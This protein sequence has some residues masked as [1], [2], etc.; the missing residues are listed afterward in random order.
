MCG[1]YI[2]TSPVDVLKA[3]FDFSETGPVSL[4]R[5]NAAPRQD[6]P[7]ITKA[8][9]SRVLKP[10]QWGLVPSWTKDLN[11]ANRP[12][13]AR[14]E[15]VAEKPSFRGPLKS[16]RV[17]V[18]ADGFYEWGE[19]PG[20]KGRVPFLFRLRDKEPFA[21]AGLS[22]VWRSPGGSL[23][24][25]FTLLTVAANALTREIHERMPAILLEEAETV[26]LDGTVN[27]ALS[28]LNPHPEQRMEA[29]E[30]SLRVNSPAF[31]DALCIESRGPL[32]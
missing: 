9:A 22:D 23:L 31:D 30:V 29:H 12:I 15:T 28:V 8:A 32:R 19:R 1:R 26:W 18:P 21:I 24:E 10:M 14:A 2:I 5:F 17:L 13:N 11:A 3:R 4:P 27:E 7:V 6:L 25:T 16:R 20:R